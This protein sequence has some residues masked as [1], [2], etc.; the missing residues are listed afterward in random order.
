MKVPDF[1]F[2]QPVRQQ[3]MAFLHRSFLKGA[4]L[5]GVVSMVMLL[6]LGIWLQQSKRIVVSGVGPWVANAVKT[7]F[8]GLSVISTKRCSR[9]SSIPRKT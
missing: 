1:I 7:E 2:Q 8:V 4:L 3:H 9:N 5:G 6:A